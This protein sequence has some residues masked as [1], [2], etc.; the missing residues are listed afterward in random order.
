MMN[1][2]SG[3]IINLRLREQH[4]RQLRRGLSLLLSVAIVLS[5]CLNLMQPASTMTTICGKEEHTHGEACY[6]QLLNCDQDGVEGHEHSA[7]CC[8]GIC[9]IFNLLP[10]EKITE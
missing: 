3:N 8:A 4:R 5:V 10:V 2:E 7:G 6:T 9:M 1:R